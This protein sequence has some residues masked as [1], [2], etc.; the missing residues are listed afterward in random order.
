MSADRQLDAMLGRVRYVGV[1]PQ[2]TE[3]EI[4]EL[5]VAQIA[6]RRAKRAAPERR[7][8]VDMPKFEI[9]VE[10]DEDRWRAYCPALEANG[11]STCGYTP[12]EAERRLR[13]VL[14]MIAAE[15]SGL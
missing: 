2:P 10:P 11:A 12:E 13:E 1:A 4:M 15:E 14:E 8:K 3:D 5:V 7:G 6:A 9:V